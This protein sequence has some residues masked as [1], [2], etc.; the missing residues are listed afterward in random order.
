MCDVPQSL[1]ALE[2]QNGQLPH[3]HKEVNEASVILNGVV[4][5]IEGSDAIAV[6]EATEVVER[7]DDIVGQVEGFE[8][9]AFFKTFDNF[10]TIVRQ[11]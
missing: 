10:Y 6:V 2:L 9:L 7:L 5:Q 4:A 8:L 3:Q 11:I 1:V